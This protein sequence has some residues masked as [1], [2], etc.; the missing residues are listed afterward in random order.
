MAESVKLGSEVS[1]AS[2][3]SQRSAVSRHEPTDLCMFHNQHG[4]T[5]AESDRFVTETYSPGSEEIKAGL[6]DRLYKPLAAS[7]P[8]IELFEQDS[9]D[10]KVYRNRFYGR[11]K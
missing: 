11:G 10:P 6:Q 1:V 9:D 4:G 2:V 8:K 3:Q 7:Q 5:I